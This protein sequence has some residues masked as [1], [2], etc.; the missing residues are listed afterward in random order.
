MPMLVC[1]FSTALVLVADQQCLPMTF[2][3]PISTSHLTNCFHN[4]FV[5]VVVVL[6]LVVLVGVGVGR[7]CCSRSSRLTVLLVVLVAVE[8]QSMCTC[9]FDDCN[10]CYTIGTCCFWFDTS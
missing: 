3:N 9:H 7:L 2:S 1:H 10:C 4:W 5:V 6:A 8:L